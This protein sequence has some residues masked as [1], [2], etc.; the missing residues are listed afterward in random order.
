MMNN[1]KNMKA[2]KKERETQGKGMDATTKGKSQEGPD[3]DVQ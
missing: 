3:S 1:E 2:E